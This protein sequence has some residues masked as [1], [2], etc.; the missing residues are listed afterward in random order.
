M[1]LAGHIWWIVPG[2]LAGTQM[3]YIHPERRLNQG[4]TLHQYDDELPLLYAAGIRAVVCLLNIPSD[5]AVYE[6]AGFTFLCAPIVDGCAP[7]LELAI[8]FI[9]FVEDHRRAGKPVVVHCEAGL[10][11]TG[12]LLAS[13]LIFQGANPSDAIAKVR[14]VERGSIETNGQIRFLEELPQ[15]LREVHDVLD[16]NSA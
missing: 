15:K 9:R 14:L 4:G 6:A 13:Y 8:R 3:P 1:A 2:V 10:G 11:R 7:T 5:A 12:T 16:G